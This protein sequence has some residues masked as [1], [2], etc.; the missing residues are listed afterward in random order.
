VGS[1]D[2]IEFNVFSR[3]TGELVAVY[4]ENFFS[5]YIPYDWGDSIAID[6]LTLH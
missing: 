6:S 3:E 1:N 4:T 5:E 2:S